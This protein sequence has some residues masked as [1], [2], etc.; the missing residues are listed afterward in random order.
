MAD[1]VSRSPHPH[2]YTVGW[3][4]RPWRSLCAQASDKSKCVMPG[5]TVR[6]I[7][8]Y[9][10]GMLRRRRFDL[11]GERGELRVRVLGIIQSRRSVPTEIRDAG[12]AARTIGIR[13][14]GR[15]RRHTRDLEALQ[16]P[17]SADCEPTAVS[18]FAG[19]RDSGPARNGLEK[20][21]YRGGVVFQ[22]RRQ[23]Y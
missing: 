6:R 23:L 12:P 17:V 18:R 13:A 21:A 14:P 2:T 9:A 15:I 5:G 22:V 11:H 10:P 1:D 8:K 4:L 3:H 16:R 20:R 19:D 7:V